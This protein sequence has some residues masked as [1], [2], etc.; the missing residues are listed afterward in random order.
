M[1]LLDLLSLCLRIGELAF[2]A[3]VAGLTG[4]YLHSTRH[5][6]AWSR[7]RFIYTEVIAGISILFSLIF[8]LPF[9]SS[10]IH[11]PFDFVLFAA[12]MIAFGLLA[13]FIGPL[14]CGGL[15]NWRGITGKGT[16][17]RWK[18]DIA[19]CFL[20]SIFFLVSALLGLYVVH[21]RRRA[22]VDS[23]RRRRWYRSTV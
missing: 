22:V 17:D 3:T 18:A 5:T 19:F 11:Y 13:D 4:A 2:S 1:L 12:W 6:S 8:L 7:K 21:K 15:W 20:A 23:T 16:C 9:M 14:H 10:F